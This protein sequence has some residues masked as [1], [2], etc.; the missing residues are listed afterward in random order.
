MASSKPTGRF[1]NLRS[2]AD[3]IE[4][5]TLG[6]TPHPEVTTEPEPRQSTANAGSLKEK[7]GSRKPKNATIRMSLDLTEEMHQQ[8][9]AIA[10]RSGLP[11]AEVVREIL[12]ETL[13]DLL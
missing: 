4:S 1:A 7:L 9:S 3:R 8:V 2:A 5:Q 6:G 12:R 13:P 11:K 10:N